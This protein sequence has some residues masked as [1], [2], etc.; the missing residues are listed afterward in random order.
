MREGCAQHALRESTVA[1]P[2]GLTRP[3]RCRS[4]LSQFAP[5]PTLQVQS[6]C[7][8]HGCHAGICDSCFSNVTPDDSLAAVGAAHA[9]NDKACRREV[10]EL[11]AHGRQTVRAWPCM[12][13]SC[14]W[15]TGSGPDH[16]NLVPAHAASLRLQVKG[17]TACRQHVICIVAGLACRRSRVIIARYAGGQRLRGRQEPC[18]HAGVAG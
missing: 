2:A 16:C 5:T 4:T 17:A 13:H 18:Q 10:A 9:D 8:A 1:L 12:R 15:S 3:A 11:Q 7:Y 6:G 14:S